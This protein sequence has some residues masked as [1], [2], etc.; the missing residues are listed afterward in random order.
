M[1]QYEMYYIGRDDGAKDG[2]SCAI[3]YLKDRYEL[4][5]SGTFWFSDTPSKPSTSWGNWHLRICS[6]VRLIN[7]ADG[8]GLYVYNLH[9]D[10][11]SQKSREN[12]AKLLAKMISQRKVKDPYIAMGDFNMH[13]DNPGMKYLQKV[14]IDTPYPRLISA[15]A[16][17]YPE[18]A[19]TVKSGHGFKGDTSGAAIDHI[20]VEK[21]TAV[22]KANIDQRTI[23]GRHP[24]DHYPVTSRVKLY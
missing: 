17:M 16:S 4:A 21:E 14:D 20:L 18:K 23:D 5:D 1:D 10:H 6:W 3:L 24:S 19:G 12:S 8:R 9:L 7:K 15:W 2:E 13:M 11:K 22:L